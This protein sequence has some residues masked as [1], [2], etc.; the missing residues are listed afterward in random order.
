MISL[1]PL[2]VSVQASSSHLAPPSILLALARAS[3]DAGAKMLRLEGVE[4]VSLLRAE[5]G[6]PVIGLIKKEY[7]GSEVYITPTLAEVTELIATGCEI[8][9][10]DGT[11]RERP[12]G[13]TFASLCAAVKAAGRLVMADCDTLLN[14]ELCVAAGADI[15]GTTLAGYTAASPSGG[16]PNL[17]LVRSLAGL[18]VPVVAE[19]R[20]SEGWQV[21]AARLAGATSVVIGGAI[22]DP[23]KQTSA[24]LRSSQVGLDGPILAVDIGGT[25]MRFASY[26]AGIMRVLERVPLPRIPEE[27]TNLIRSYAARAS[28]LRVA[29]STGGT[30][31]PLTTEVWEAK[32][33][34]PDYVGTNFRTALPDLEIVALNDGLATAWGH[35]C[36]PQFAGMRVATL[37]LGTGVGFG[38]VD[39]GRILKGTRGDYPRLNDM[40]TS[41]GETFE[42]L[43]GGAALS[44]SPTPE[45]KI[46][47]QRAADEAIKLVRSLYYPDAIVL[48]G[49]VGLADWLSVDAVRSPYG[50]D[51]GLYG[52]AMLLAAFPLV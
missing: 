28:T 25:W 13:S 4:A 14:A 24:F 38:L 12:D 3:V 31:D 15:V 45:Q 17:D 52:A 19:G 29:I 50:A 51:A 6:I 49:G 36:L 42:D 35:A 39:R 5:L 43:L 32:P 22:N 18:S 37:A 48:C 11:D 46:F 41:T 27:R 23:L 34:I 20:Y 2:I 10:L 30:V 40:K 44:S 47:A 26:E 16:G 9:A 21:Q 8:I 33:I 7:S 1:P